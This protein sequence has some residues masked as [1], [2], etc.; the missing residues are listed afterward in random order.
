[1]GQQKSMM[2]MG[3]KDEPRNE[4]TDDV[5]WLDVCMQD[6]LLMDIRQSVTNLPREKRDEEEEPENK[7]Q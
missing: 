5:R 6:P 3:K 7:I 1:M 2:M 4:I